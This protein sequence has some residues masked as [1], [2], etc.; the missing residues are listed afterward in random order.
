MIEQQTRNSHYVPQW[1]QRGFLAP[2]QSRFFRFN[3][4]PDRKT[5]SEGRQVPRNAL[6]EWG[7]ANCFVEYDLNS[8]PSPGCGVADAR[9]TGNYE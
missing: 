8:W 6:H 9:R 4:D 7:P 2:G 5:L 3:L 1:Y